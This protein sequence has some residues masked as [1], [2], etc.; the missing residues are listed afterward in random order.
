MDYLGEV[1]DADAI[2]ARYPVGNTG[3]YALRLSKSLFIDAALVRGVGASANAPPPGVRANARFVV[4]PRTR[5]ARL[6]VS[7]HIDAGGEILVSYGPEY[8]EVADCSHTTSDVPQWEWDL[9]KTLLGPEVAKIS[10]KNPK[11]GVGK[12]TTSCRVELRV[13]WSLGTFQVA[14]IDKAS[15]F[16]SRECDRPK[17]PPTFV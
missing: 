3:I 17:C 14:S 5:S 10:L 12:K 4:N 1:L 16:E 15:D 7:R 13:S 8:G 9:S 2:E 6:E 11:R